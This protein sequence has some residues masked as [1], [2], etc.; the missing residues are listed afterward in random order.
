MS[1]DLR[2]FVIREI[3]IYFRGEYRTSLLFLLIGIVSVAGG[4][5]AIV[6]QYLVLL[7]AALPLLLFGGLYI[8]MAV[9]ILKR[10]PVRMRLLCERLPQD[11]ALAREECDRIDRLSAKWHRMHQIVIFL[12]AAGLLALVGCVIFKSQGFVY[13]LALALVGHSAIDIVVLLV[14][15]FRTQLYKHAIEKMLI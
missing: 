9:Q 11:P 10:I 5:A 15:R 2:S 8:A 12:F 4:V 13:G 1:D 6:T 14:S 7:G 3:R